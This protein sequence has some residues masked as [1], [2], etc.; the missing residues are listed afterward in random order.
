MSKLTRIAL[1]MAVLVPTP[2]WPDSLE[3]IPLRHRTVEQVLPVLRPLLEPGGTVSGTQNTLIVRTSPKNLAD[4]KQVLANIDKAPRRLLILVRQ[5]ASS[6]VG[7]RAA[8]LSGTVGAGRVVI[9]S[10]GSASERG[11]TARASDTRFLSE[12]GIVQ[13]IQVLEGSPAMIHTGQ[14]VPT[15]S[16]TVTPGP[17]GA[18]INESVTYREVTSGFEVMPRLIGDQVMLD[19]SPRRETPGAAGSVDIQR[20]AST[21]SGRLGEWFE[22]GEMVQDQSGRQTGPLSGSGALR[23]DYRRIWVKVEEIN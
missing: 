12:S 23:Q 6:S 1:V 9:G 5:D 11:V 7:Q 4:L 21:V 22:L 2:A 10:G 19:I 18:V 13:Q 20:A 17:R 8:E 16:R 14:S 3:I 15:V